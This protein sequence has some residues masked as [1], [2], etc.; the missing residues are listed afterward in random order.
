MNV[1]CFRTQFDLLK[2]VRRLKTNIRVLYGGQFYRCS[3]WKGFAKVGNTNLK[4][5]GKPRCDPELA[6]L[7]KARVTRQSS[8]DL[9]QGNKLSKPAQTR[10]RTVG[11]LM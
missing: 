2:F 4:R 3:L 1:D 5:H 6:E 8:H 7:K 9:R 11:S 10:E